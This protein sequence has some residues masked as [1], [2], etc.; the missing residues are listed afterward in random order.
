MADYDGD[1]KADVGIYRPSDGTWYIILSSNGANVIVNN[2]GTTP[3]P[4][5]YSGDGKADGVIFTDGN[6]VGTSSTGDPINI[7]WGQAGDIATPGDFDGDNIV[8]QAVFRPS[9]GVWYIRQSSNGQPSIVPFG[10]TGDLPVVGDY[11][12]DGKDDIAIYRNGQWWIN[13]SGGGV[14]IAN[15]GIATDKPAP[16]SANP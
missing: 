9:T 12:G 7:P 15:F 1:G 8:D 6:W 3:V 4:A 2:P 5:D 10:T 11:D 16:A 13:N 14:T